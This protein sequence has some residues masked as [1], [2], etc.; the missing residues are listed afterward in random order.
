M[1]HRN[2]RPVKMKVGLILFLQDIRK[3]RDFI[4]FVLYNCHVVDI[5]SAV[6]QIVK[7]NLMRLPEPSNSG[8]V[9]R[10]SYFEIVSITLG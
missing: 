4:Q 7:G 1:T 8:D 10:L 9:T 6:L 2:R 5:Q 3:V